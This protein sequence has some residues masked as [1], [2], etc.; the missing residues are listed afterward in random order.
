MRW[1]YFIPIFFFIYIPVPKADEN[2]TSIYTLPGKYN[3]FYH[4]KYTLKKAT[5][6][7]ELSDKRRLTS[8]FLDGGQFE[9]LIPKEQFP[10]SAPNCKKHIILRM[11]WTNPA[12]LNAPLFIEQKRH[13]FGQIE[14]LK[15]GDVDEID[16]VIEL[17]PYV[18]VKNQAPL[19]LELER[20]NV[21]F[22]HAHG[23][24]VDYVG[25]LK[26]QGGR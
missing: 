23:Q 4:V 10:V 25:P 13:L 1:F 9:V 18:R 15:K 6:C 3:D 22:R 21:F 12:L 7:R 24:Y 20:C 16:V 17:N 8:T 26:S 19:E 2:S 14:A 11:P 5:I